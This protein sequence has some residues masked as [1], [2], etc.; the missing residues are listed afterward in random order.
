MISESQHAFGER[1]QILDAVLVATEVVDEIVGTN[2][3]EILCKLDME[4]A[5]DHVN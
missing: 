2:E 4:K 1:R 3:N 5:Y